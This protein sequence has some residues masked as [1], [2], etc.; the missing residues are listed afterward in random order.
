MKLIKKDNVIAS[1]DTSTLFYS[2]VAMKKLFLLVACF[3]VCSLAAI[4]SKLVPLSLLRVISNQSLD[5]MECQ[6]PT[7]GLCPVP[8]PNPNTCRLCPTPTGPNPG[9]RYEYR[10][11][12]RCIVPSPRTP[13]SDKRD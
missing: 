3:S 7:T 11:K 4:D 5:C 9:G 1:I 2:R 12:S 6:T 13:S 10:I 8:S